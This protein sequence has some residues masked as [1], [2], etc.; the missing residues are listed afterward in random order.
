MDARDKI[1][2]VT[3][4]RISQEVMAGIH[5]SN[6]LAFSVNSPTHPD[7]V[8]RETEDTARM[9]FTTHPSLSAISSTTQF[10]RGSV[11]QHHQAL[12]FADAVLPT[13]GIS[14]ASRWAGLGVFISFTG[15][16]TPGSLYIRARQKS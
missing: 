8:N 6:M 10:C 16:R 3:M 1:C 12:F 14:A 9:Q 2:I 4:R 7:Q 11:V 13:D 5:S 15:S